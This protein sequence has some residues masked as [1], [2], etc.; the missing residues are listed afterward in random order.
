MHLVPCFV[1]KLGKMMT[2]FL[3]IDYGGTNTKAIIVDAYG[4]QMGVSSFETLRIEKQSGYREVDL[5]KTWQA[6]SSS[7]KEV[8]SKTRI[9]A[10]DIAAV[11][12]IGHGKGLYLLDKKGKEFVN[13]ILSTDARAS[14]LAKQF[15]ASI[16]QI[17]PLTQQHVF[18][19]QSPVLLRWLKDNQP[20]I[21][22]EIGFVLSAKDY[23]RF[24]LT[25]KINQE[26]GDAS[27][28]HWINFQTGTYDSDLL[29][30]FGIE[31]MKASLP[32]LVDCRELVGGVTPQAA[33]ATGLAVGTP[34]VAGLFDIDACAI[35][36]GVLDDKTFSVISGTWNINTYPSK[37]A[38]SQMSGQM[39]SYFLDKS[40]LVEASSP[41]SAGNLDIILKL[42]MSEE[43]QNVKKEGKESIYDTLEV[44]LKE[45]DAAY[46][47]LLFFPFL[48]GSN[49]SA[50][51][52]ACFFGLTSTSSKSEMLRA[53]YEGISFAHKQ[54]ID[55]LIAG[56]GRVP[57]KIR[58]SGGA[59]NSKAWMQLFADVLNI[60][61]EIVEGTELGGLGGAIIALQATQGLSLEEAVAQMVRVKER[62]TPNLSEHKIYC[63]KYH[64]YQ[65]VLVAMEPVWKGLRA[66][67]NLKGEK[68]DG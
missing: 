64:V 39:N 35:G 50:D 56:R 8:L 13:G 45:T 1:R 67:E 14:T 51:A 31:E 68:G 12:C 65:E 34:V 66:L 44:F 53:V 27:G 28:N 16:D 46:Q 25:G 37:K 58:L 48:Y 36:S 24:K 4:K 40:F 18:A 26:Y 15:E 41:T 60:P 52:K 30:F 62:F 61:I 11:S 57:D 22:Q 38:A 6:I 54:H 43:M 3:S 20:S 59:S 29:S 19:V 21:Y 9:D 2:Y 55:Q 33:E 49:A 5:L 47:N 23:V 32:E 63:A 17:W 7:I 10:K 42:L